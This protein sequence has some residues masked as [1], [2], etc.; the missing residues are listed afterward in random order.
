VEFKS[1]NKFEKL[2][3]LVGFIIRKKVNW[4]HLQGCDWH[5]GTAY[6]MVNVIPNYLVFALTAEM[7]VPF[8]CVC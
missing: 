5:E 8:L 6:F 7:P 3:H 4:L 2:V 1:K